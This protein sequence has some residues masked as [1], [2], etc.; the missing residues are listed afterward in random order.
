MRKI[1]FLAVLS[2]LI[3][4]CKK[5]ELKKPTEV[6]F[7]FDLN[8]NFTP[9]STIKMI[10]GD[11]NF[12]DFSITGDRVE[13]QDISFS[14]S[15]QSGL[16]IDLNG[17]GE[18][19]EMDFDIPQGE[20]TDLNVSFNI[21]SDQNNLALSLDG[22]YKITQGPVVA[23][24]FEYDGGNSFSISGEGNTAG[25]SIIMDADLG[26]KGRIKFDP[27]YW[28]GSLTANQMDNAT[29]IPMQGQDMI[30]LSSTS[31]V[32]LYEIVLNRISSSNTAIFE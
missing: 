10:S 13:G 3:F 6:N 16:Y 11:I 28:F 31:N 30:L 20:Y 2:V 29:I 17:S 24:R 8:K 1:Y 4:S 23:L 27:I 32:S 22:T 26:K 7:T 18:I 5:A 9:A 15:F 19:A 25:Q 21:A 12:I 14:R